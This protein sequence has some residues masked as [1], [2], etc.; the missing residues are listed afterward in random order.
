MYES[1]AKSVCIIS[2]MAAIRLSYIHILLLL[3]FRT[4]VT[5]NYQQIL[6]IYHRNSYGF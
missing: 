4:F 2:M 5:N 6:K 1:T 3:F